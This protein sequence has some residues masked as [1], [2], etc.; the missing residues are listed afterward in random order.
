MRE[1]YIDLHTHTTLSDGTYTPQ[2]L[3]DMAQRA[4]IGILA[5]TD[6]NYSENLAPLQTACPNIR[7]IQGAEISCLYV[8]FCGREIEI[9]VVALGFDPDNP[10]IK[11]VLTHNQ[12]DRKPYINAILDRLRLCGIDL[13]DYEDLHRLYPNKRHIGRM[14]IART[15]KD[16][17]FVD[18][19]DQGFDVYIGSFG[20]KRAY[21]PNPLRYVS[22]EEA[23]NAIVNAGGAAVLA[24]LYYYQLNSN[25][26]EQLVKR[27]KELVGSNGAMEVLY[28]RYNQE[29]RKALMA[30]ADKYNLMYSAASDFH[31]QSESDTLTNKF[32]KSSC[33]ELLE[34]LKIR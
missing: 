17:R 10:D 6:H 12:P 14:D 25:D 2:Q 3:C 15:L 18:T 13:G 34:F 4:N 16:R 28:S 31:G 27:F 9:H 30:L 22:I 26:S 5:L 21:V 8:D 29:Q 11:A 33:S 24:H 1:T 7:F 23:V 20:E 32:T 19:V